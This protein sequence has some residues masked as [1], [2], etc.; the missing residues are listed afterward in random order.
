MAVKIN[1]VEKG[2]PAYKKGMREGDVLLFINEKAKCEN[3]TLSLGDAPCMLKGV[4]HKSFNAVLYCLT[5]CA[6]Y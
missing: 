3:K 6:R 2:S 1:K 4:E 5:G